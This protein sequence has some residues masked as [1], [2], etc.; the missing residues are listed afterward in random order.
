MRV[1][2]RHLSAVAAEEVVAVAVPGGVNLLWEPSGARDVAGYLVLRSE[3]PGATLTPLMTKPVT[4]LSYRDESVRA[5]VRYIYAV[6]AVDAA[7]NRSQ[8][9]NRVEETAQ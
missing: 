8:E 4:T 7:G 1:V 3:T 2:C 5:G 6:V 9:S